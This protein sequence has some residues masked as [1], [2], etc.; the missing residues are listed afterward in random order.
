LRF[1]VLDHQT[2]SPRFELAKAAEEI[3]FPGFD[4]KNHPASSR[5]C[6]WGRSAVAMN[7]CIAAGAASVHAAELFPFN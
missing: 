1:A 6:R 2:D 4:R 5:L 3:T 7:Y